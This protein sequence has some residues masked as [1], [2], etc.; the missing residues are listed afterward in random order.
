MTAKKFIE[1][2]AFGVDN[3]NVV[4]IKRDALIA[5]E[6]AELEAKISC[7]RATGLNIEQYDCMEQL[8]LLKSKHKIR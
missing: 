6:L 5:I 7:Y 1:S 3:W 8:E 2:K 4:V